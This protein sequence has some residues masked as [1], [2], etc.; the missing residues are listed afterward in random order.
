MVIIVAPG[1]YAFHGMWISRVDASIGDV[2]GKSANSEW[3]RV[4]CGSGTMRN[5]RLEF[6]RN[7]SSMS[8]LPTLANAD[9]TPI[10]Q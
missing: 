5:S 3:K 4:R 6:K 10:S 9:E 2:L 7:A 8:S 1:C